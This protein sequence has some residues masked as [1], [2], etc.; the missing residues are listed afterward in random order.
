MAHNIFKIPFATIYEMYL[1]KVT[2]KGRTE[3][4]LVEVLCYLTGHDAE[5]LKEQLNSPVTLET[6]F[7]LA[8]MNPDAKLITG[9]ICGYKVEEI[10]DPLMQ[11]I[12]YADK[13]VDELAKGR[14]LNKIMRKS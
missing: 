4:E 10:S 12:R 9:S 3:A 1:Q 11:K 8:R 14:P 6:F 7:T 5:S 2:A 13:L